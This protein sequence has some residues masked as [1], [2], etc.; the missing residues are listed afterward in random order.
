MLHCHSAA[1][2]EQS[3]FL[4]P[5]FERNHKV[6]RKLAWTKP[7]LQCVDVTTLKSYDVK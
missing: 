3:I 5:A 7:T 1:L 6:S 2:N 4:P